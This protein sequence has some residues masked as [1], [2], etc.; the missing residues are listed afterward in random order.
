MGWANER[1]KGGI[2][3]AVA[4][5]C[6]VVAFLDHVPTWVVDDCEHWQRR[7]RGENVR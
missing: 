5:R 3:V 4:A 6:H 1:W 2:V 7:C